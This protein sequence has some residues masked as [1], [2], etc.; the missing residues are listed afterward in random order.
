MPVDQ[1][2]GLENGDGAARVIL[3]GQAAGRTGGEEER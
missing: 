1:G 2:D 3:G